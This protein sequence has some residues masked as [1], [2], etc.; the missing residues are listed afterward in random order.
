MRTSSSRNS[1]W[2]PR[3]FTCWFGVLVFFV[4][5]AD[6]TLGLRTFALGDFDVFGY[7]LAHHHRES[8]LRGEMPL[9]NPLNNFGL[10]FLA[11]WN[12]MVLYPCLLYTSDAADE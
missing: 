5:F 4:S 12:T 10:P 8:F 11:Q 1:P 6:I 2:T 9:W 3:V 7:P